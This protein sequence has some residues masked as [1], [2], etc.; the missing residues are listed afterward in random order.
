MLSP[1]PA[2]IISFISATI[3]S[4]NSIHPTQPPTE[5][6]SDNG[7][8]LAVKALHLQFT[9]LEIFYNILHQLA[10]NL[11]Q[12]QH[13]AAVSTKLSMCVGVFGV[14]FC[15]SS[16]CIRIFSASWLALII[17]LLFLSVFMI[18]FRVDVAFICALLGLQ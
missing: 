7:H 2:L 12:L 17:I 4:I 14:F 5:A 16:F 13:T 18:N 11:L 1:F 15:I 10:E 3:Y 6:H 9:R 8:W